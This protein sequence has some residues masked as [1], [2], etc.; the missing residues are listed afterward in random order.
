MI[1]YPVLVQLQAAATSEVSLQRWS[2]MWTDPWG[3]FLSRQFV[4][5]TSHPTHSLDFGTDLSVPRIWRTYNNV[6]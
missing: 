5:E 4:P 6:A 1:Y 2:R 3:V